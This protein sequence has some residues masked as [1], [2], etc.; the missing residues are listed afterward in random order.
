MKHN[1]REKNRV[2]YL[3]ANKGANKDLFGR[4]TILTVPLV[5]ANESFWVDILGTV[6]AR[7]IMDC[8]IKGVRIF[9]HDIIFFLLSWL[10]RMN[11]QYFSRACTF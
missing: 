6:F 11:N 5:F 7:K 9:L 2:A 8:N 3:M 4:T 1:Y 10:N